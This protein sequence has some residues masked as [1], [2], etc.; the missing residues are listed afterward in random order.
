MQNTAGH[1]PKDISYLSV[2]N[3]GDLGIKLL[4]SPIN[5]LIT[6]VTC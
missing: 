6:Q 2:Y 5:Y 1:F 3:V 4:G